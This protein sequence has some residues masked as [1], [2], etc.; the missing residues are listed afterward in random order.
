M[1]ISLSC[2]LI[3]F[4]I[5]APVWHVASAAALDG[6]QVPDTQQVDGRT[7]HLNG[8]GLRTYSIQGIHILG[9]RRRDQRL[10]CS[11]PCADLLGAIGVE[12]ASR[13]TRL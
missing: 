1:Q 7:L 5:I 8:Y 4:I 11:V 10:Q 6:L 9:Q 2:A 13:S 3:T 12:V